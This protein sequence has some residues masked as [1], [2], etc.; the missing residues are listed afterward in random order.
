M[1]FK[2]SLKQKQKTT[3][4]IK[5]R[6]IKLEEYS[7]EELVTMPEIKGPSD[8]LAKRKKSEEAQNDQIKR[9]A[10]TGIVEVFDAEAK[11]R[12]AYIT[13]G[14][15]QSL[16]K[17]YESHRDY[18]KTLVTGIFKTVFDDR[19]ARHALALLPKSKVEDIKKQ[20][21]NALAPLTEINNQ[22]KADNIENRNQAR[23]NVQKIINKIR[24]K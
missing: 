7:S 17:V 12:L 24:P 10:S 13:D 14:L 23:E 3:P 4:I 15:D 2:I 18:V 9:T 22:F 5:P 16:Q 6:I 20:L 1:E 11:K 8:E 19:E 21:Q